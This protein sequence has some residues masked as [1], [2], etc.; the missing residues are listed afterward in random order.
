MEFVSNAMKFQQQVNNKHAIYPFSVD[1]VVVVAI[2]MNR[3][4]NINE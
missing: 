3:T 4:N 2:W 1:V